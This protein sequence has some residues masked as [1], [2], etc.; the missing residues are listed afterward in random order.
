M[1]I[2]IPLELN[3]NMDHLKDPRKSEQKGYCIRG[4]NKDDGHLILPSF[5]RKTVLEAA[6]KNRGNKSNLNGSYR[7]SNSLVIQRSLQRIDSSKKILSPSK[8]HNQS[9]LNVAFGSALST[10]PSLVQ[11]HVD[12]S[13]IITNTNGHSNDLNSISESDDDNT[14]SFT[15]INVEDK[16]IVRPFKIDLKRKAVV[17][18]DRKK[19]PNDKK[20]SE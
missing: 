5:W 13:T 15:P 3:D 1:P 9:H 17:P 10:F 16:L 14:C 12:N 20:K 18:V 4:Q 8:S 2:E 6:N 11:S 19:S 7:L